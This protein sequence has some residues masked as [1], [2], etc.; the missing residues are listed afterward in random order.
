M[1]KLFFTLL[2]L[3]STTLS[4][5]AQ[6]MDI[7]ETMEARPIVEVPR[8]K[9][10]TEN[11]KVVF[12]DTIALKTTSDAVY[13]N[14]SK[15]IGKL[16]ST[17]KGKVLE[18]DKV[19]KEINLLVVDHLEIEK[20]ALSLYSVYLEYTV[21]I[22][23]RD[24]YCITRVENLKYTEPQEIKNDDPYSMQGEEVLLTNKFKVLFVPDAAEKV[25]TK[26]V[27]SLRNLFK[28]LRKNIDQ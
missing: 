17:K 22:V 15:W 2:L 19:N 20:K 18:N 16:L 8:F 26:T 28:S 1:E 23:Y 5:S 24:G 25:K 3:I 11:G 4:I 7:D 13:P 6:D 27:S 21:H 14:I 10:P 12:V 9:I